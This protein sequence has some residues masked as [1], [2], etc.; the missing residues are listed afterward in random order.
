MSYDLHMRIWRGDA[1]G[2]DFVSYTV[3]VEEGEVR[4]LDERW[5]IAP[6]A[7]AA[8]ERVGHYSRS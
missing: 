4:V 8:F 7:Q 6:A 3:S 5:E 1:T 2:G